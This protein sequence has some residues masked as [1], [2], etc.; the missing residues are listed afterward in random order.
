[1]T[2]YSESQTRSGWRPQKREVPVRLYLTG[3]EGDTADLVGV[4][5][6]GLPLE[7]NLV[8]VTD[9]IDPDEL[10]GAAAAVIQVDA[11]T[12]ASVKR[13]QKLAKAVET[14]LIAAAYDPPLALVRSL[15]RTGA[16]DVLPLPLEL[17]EVEASLR[18]EQDQHHSTAAADIGF[19]PGNTKDFSI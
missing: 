19:A 12:P 2:A 17:D 5:A 8:P 11:E 4:R 15:L 13:F 10:G 9:W 1:M 18:Q 6:A 7:L 3:V 16:C 14:P